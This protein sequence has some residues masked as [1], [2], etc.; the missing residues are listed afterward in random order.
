MLR[1]QFYLYRL[2]NILVVEVAVQ[3]VVGNLLWVWYVW[4][5]VWVRVSK[6]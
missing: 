2:K 5:E 4:G 1:R 3:I 6:M